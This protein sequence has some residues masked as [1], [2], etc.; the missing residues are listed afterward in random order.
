MEYRCW[1][2]FVHCLCSSFSLC[3]SAELQLSPKLSCGTQISTNVAVSKN[4]SILVE[5][6]LRLDH[7]SCCSLACNVHNQLSGLFTWKKA[8][9]RSFYQTG[10]VTNQLCWGPIAQA[11]C[12]VAMVQLKI[13]MKKWYIWLSQLWNW[14]FSWRLHVACTIVS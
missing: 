5:A 2:V 3:F 9:F 14:R 4:I 10:Y 12:I 7:W 8:S 11:V 13:L 6:I 1:T